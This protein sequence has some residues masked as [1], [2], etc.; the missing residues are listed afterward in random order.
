[1]TDFYKNRLNAFLDIDK[2]R[3]EGR[4]EIE[5]IYIIQTRYGFG[6]SMIRSRINLLDNI[7]DD[8][9]KEK[10]KKYKTE[11]EARKEATAIL[12]R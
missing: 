11:E 10:E 7:T 2:L 8:V 4:T 3:N 12:G 5:I 6:E 9:A 1:M